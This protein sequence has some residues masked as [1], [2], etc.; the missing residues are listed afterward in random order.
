MREAMPLTIVERTLLM[1]YGRFLKFTKGESVLGAGS[2]L[3]GIY[4]V[5]KGSLLLAPSRRAASPESR[6]TLAPGHLFGQELPGVPE[7]SPYRIHCL[8]DSTLIHIDSEALS[9]LMHEH[10]TLGTRLLM[11]QQQ[12]RQAYLESLADSPAGGLVLAV[13]GPRG[14]AGAS[15]ATIAMAGLAVDLQVRT[16][17]ID[18]HPYF[19]EIAPLCEWR[20][21]GDLSSL[22]DGDLS[23]E[24]LASHASTGRDFDVLAGPRKL[25][26]GESLSQESL[27]PLLKL[28][29]IEYDLVLLDLPES[30]TEIVLTS[31][32]LADHVL[33]VLTA[34]FEGLLAG[35]RV[36]ELLS[37]LDVPKDVLWVLMNRFR[38]SGGITP[39]QLREMLDWPTAVTAEDSG[40]LLRMA[41]DGRL[42]EVAKALPDHPLVS[43]CR[44][45]LGRILGSQSADATPPP[46]IYMEERNLLPS[47]LP[48]LSEPGSKV[49]ILPSPVRSSLLAR[50]LIALL[51]FF[52]LS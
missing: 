50:A 29:A 25:E 34:D 51:G 9:L 7:V 18:L 38:G 32:E 42:W 8:E 37:M 24:R 17:I 22:L 45:F 10:L 48:N 1:N 23:S 13:Y 30:I 2:S 16:L 4:L 11:Q 6:Q 41:N 44:F 27:A 43:A 36:R 14:G 28:A 26:D 46:E 15:S 49:H 47:I 21:E 19:G 12:A 20:P 5:F 33:L 3:D 35:R 40:Q 52:G 39:S 31:L